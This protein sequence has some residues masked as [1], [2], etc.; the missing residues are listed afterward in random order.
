MMNSWFAKMETGEGCS[1]NMFTPVESRCMNRLLCMLKLHFFH[2]DIL[3]LQASSFG[4]VGGIL[5]CHVEYTRLL[6]SAIFG[7]VETKA[8]DII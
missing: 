3:S 1:F 7:F 2:C 4:Y 8:E 5:S 6:S